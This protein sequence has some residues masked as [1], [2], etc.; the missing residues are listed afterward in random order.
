MLIQLEQARSMAILAASK[1]DSAN[2][3]ERR[4][5]VAAAKEMIG[6][7][8]RY[9]GQQ[10]IQLHGGMGMTDELN[11]SHYFRRLTAIDLLFGNAAYQR[12]RFATIGDEAPAAQMKA[13]RKSWVRI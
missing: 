11:A 5:A 13:P 10:A 12:A 2:G 8:G 4:K 3:A 1:V 9:V 7:A 6:R